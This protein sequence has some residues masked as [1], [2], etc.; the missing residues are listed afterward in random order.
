ML[1]T[2]KRPWEMLDVERKGNIIVPEG[3]YPLERIDNP[4]GH[5]EPWLVIKGTE[6]GMAESF[7]RYWKNGKIIND[8]GHPYHGKLADWGEF[9]IIIEE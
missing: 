6:I 5:L 4:F 9:E 3:R 2:L 8:P 7:W 1:A